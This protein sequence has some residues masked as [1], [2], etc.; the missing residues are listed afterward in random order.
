MVKPLEAAL[1]VALFLGA[2]LAAAEDA[3]PDAAWLRVLSRDLQGTSSKLIALAKATPEERFGWS[4]TPEVRTVSEVYMHIVATSLLIPPGLGAPAPEGIVIPDSSYGL[5][6]L[7]RAG[8][9]ETTSKE[10]VVAALERSSKY[11]IASI[12]EIEGLDEQVAIFGFPGSKRDYLMLIVGHAQEHLGQSIAYARAMGVTPPWSVRP[13]RPSPT[14]TVEIDGK[15]AHGVIRA[16]DQFGNLLT[17]FVDADLEQI[18]TIAGTFVEI[19]ACGEIAR[20]FVGNQIFDVRPGEWILYPSPD[21]YWS[22]AL[23]FASAARSLGCKG[24]EA[25]AIRL[26]E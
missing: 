4:P 11:A 16:V 24:E 14:S 21:G 17:S 26:V 12:L 6:E 7:G 18:E 19:Q 10:A 20:L 22:V 1:A 3:S 13:E 2:P 15:T 5:S 25:I 8:E 23:S 9:A